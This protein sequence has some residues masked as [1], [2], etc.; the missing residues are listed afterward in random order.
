MARAIA[1]AQSQR[2]A[3]QLAAFGHSQELARSFSFVSMLGLAFAI[4]NSWTA[5]STS[6]S[7][8]LPS[9]GPVAVMWGLLAAGFGSLALA[10][11][12]AEFLSSYPTSAG[13]YHWA[14]I[15]SPPK[16]TAIVSWVTGWINVGGWVALSASGGV[17]GASL[18]CGLI[19]LYSPDFSPQPWQQF[20]V[21]LL[22]TFLG[23]VTNMFMGSALPVVTKAALFWSIIG[24]VT[25]SIVILARASPEFQPA[26][27]VFGDFS[28]STGWPDGVAFLL[29][30]LQGALGLV[31]S[32]AVAHMIE[33]IPRPTV[34]GPRIMIACVV[35]G[36]VTGFIFLVCLLF[37]I[38]DADAVVVSLKGPLI[39]IFFQA[40]RNQAATACITIFPLLCLVFATIGIM[41]T[42]TRMVYAFAR[43]GGLPFSR[44]FAKVHPR[45]DIPLNA[46]IL[47]NVVVVIFGL[48][49]L[50]STSA[51]NAILSASVIALSVSYA[52]APAINCMRG[53]KMLLSGRSFVLP[54]WLGWACNLVSSP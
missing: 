53:R 22:Y 2:D 25:I 31:G 12:N 15:I 23:F 29:G 45:L 21:Y 9:G 27:F 54:N 48:I 30:L 41:A 1:D 5:L 28:N 39:E 7:L 44:V 51:F 11:S 24:F 17:L 19:N 35:I 4:L 37:V 18:L 3:A 8:A 36:I 50:G 10:A 52:I 47:T 34:H 20:L 13:Q 49:Y 46:L 32:D 42:S 43:D 40:T 26:S 16:Y 14:A 6:L 33:E 38:T